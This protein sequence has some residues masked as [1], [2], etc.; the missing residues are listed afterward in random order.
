M[1]HY[2]I[3]QKFKTKESN[4]ICL[5]TYIYAIKNL[6]M[7]DNTHQVQAEGKGWSDNNCVGNTSLKKKGK[8]V[9]LFNRGV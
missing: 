7:Q 9:N 8:N 2:I 6:N 4:L 3:R 1:H 5:W